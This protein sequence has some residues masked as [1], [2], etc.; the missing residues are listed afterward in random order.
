MSTL[1]QKA[2]QQEQLCTLHRQLSYTAV[3]NMVC[4]CEGTHY[5]RA[6]PVEVAIETAA[7]SDTMA[8]KLSEEEIAE[9]REIF[10]LVD[11]VRCC[12]R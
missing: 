1:S 4:A 8:D 11:R 7:T 3:W 5:G 6:Q 2:V 10:S 12:L 9:F